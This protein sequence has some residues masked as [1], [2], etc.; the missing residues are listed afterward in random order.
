M[1]K[2]SNHC[3]VQL[4]HG[5]VS[6]NSDF[7][8]KIIILFSILFSTF[9][10]NAVVYSITNSSLYADTSVHISSS[11]ISADISI[12]IEP[13]SLF[14]DKNIY[15][16]RGYCNLISDSGSE[17][18]VALTDSYLSADRSV[19]IASSSLFADETYSI[20]SSSLIAD[21]VI[22]VSD[23][24]SDEKVIAIYAALN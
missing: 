21:D 23:S 14:A 22:C 24:I 8:T 17:I 3:F 15:I 7:K 4:I 11:S 6:L 18:S 20:A 19:F 10:L 9:N 2:K 1:N 16:D 5:G 12:Y 13:S